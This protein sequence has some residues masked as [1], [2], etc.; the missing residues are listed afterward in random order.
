MSSPVA[1]IRLKHNKRSGK[2]LVYNM[3]SARENLHRKNI[4]DSIDFNK[5]VAVEKINNPRR[6][7]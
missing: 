4:T 7:I 2:N 5:K 6:L 3:E 1:D